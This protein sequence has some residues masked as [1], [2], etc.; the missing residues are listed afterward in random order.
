MVCSQV[1]WGHVLVF[2]HAYHM[3]Q[4]CAS[5]VHGLNQTN[6]FKILKFLGQILNFIFKLPKKLSGKEIFKV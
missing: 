2:G 1:T 3:I 4:S 5:C 6:T